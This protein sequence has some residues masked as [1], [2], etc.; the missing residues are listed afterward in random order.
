MARVP[1]VTRRRFLS[2]TPLDFLI[3][4]YS[5]MIRIG[6]PGKVHYLQRSRKKIDTVACLVPPKKKKNYSNRL[7][8]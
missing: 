5:T 1:D 2:G 4:G 8:E 3:Q 6:P 7:A